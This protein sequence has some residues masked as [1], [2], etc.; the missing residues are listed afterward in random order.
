MSGFNPAAGEAGKVNGMDHAA[1]ACNPDWWA[2]ML[3]ALAEVARKKPFL[4]TD[5]IEFIRQTR[6]GPRTHENRALGPLMREAQKLGICE[7]TDQWVP[8]SQG[9][10]HR[11]F[12][13][14]WYSLIYQG[15]PVR[16]PR[17]RKISDPRQYDMWQGEQL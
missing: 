16:K 8:S 14:V 5:D 7:P 12:M 1:R 11:R 9:V 17:R 10:N 4:F 13:R 3:A 15:P 2:F 6:Q